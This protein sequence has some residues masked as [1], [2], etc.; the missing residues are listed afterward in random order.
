M[1]LNQ[2]TFAVVGLIILAALT[3]LIPH[4]WNMT[5]VGAM[6]IFGGTYLRPRI[7]SVVV[8]LLALFVSDAVLGFYSGMYVTYIAFALVAVLGWWL[9]TEIT[10]A[11]VAFASVT[12]S[13]L[14]FFVSNF[15]VWAQS[16]MYTKTGE[17][18]LACYVMAVPF[19]GNQ[20]VGDLLYASL[21][22]SAYELVA[23]KYLVEAKA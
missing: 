21:L 20:I 17:G 6:A 23:K 14:F 5:A 13:M 2:K 11:K 1:N 19:L 4:P 18:L 9:A 10:A 8:P 22:F 15:G 3:R 7:L 16:G 12:G